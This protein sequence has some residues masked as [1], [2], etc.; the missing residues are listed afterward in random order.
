MKR[1]KFKFICCDRQLQ[2][3]SVYQK[4]CRGKISILSN[5][6]YCIHGFMQV[7]KENHY[8][9]MVEKEIHAIYI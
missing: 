5:G 8:L 2:K 1:L 9:L 7:C 4:S 3:K 6:P